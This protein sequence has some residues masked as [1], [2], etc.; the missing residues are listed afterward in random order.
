MWPL[1]TEQFKLFH[2]PH[3]S[4]SPLNLHTPIHRSMFWPPGRE[5]AVITAAPKA[6]TFFCVMRRSF[7]LTSCYTAFFP[8]LSWD[9][10]EM[11][12]VIFVAVVCGFC[13]WLYIFAIN[14]SVINNVES[15]YPRNKFSLHCISMDTVWVLELIFRRTKRKG[16]LFFFFLLLLEVLSPEIH[17]P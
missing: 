3:F 9:H 5:Y 10:V 6:V 12:P 14:H 1:V 2:A 17:V 15:H 13:R 4:Q 11:A 16:L 7:L 8:T